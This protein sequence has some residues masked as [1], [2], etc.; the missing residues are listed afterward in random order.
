MRS[1]CLL[2]IV[3]KRVGLGT[4]RISEY[5][6]TLELAWKAAGD[7]LEGGQ[8]SGEGV[9]TSRERLMVMGAV[10]SKIY[11]HRGVCS[12]EGSNACHISEVSLCPVSVSLRTL[13]M[14]SLLAAG[15]E[16]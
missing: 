14:I 9:T 2:C 6:R 13:A 5:F 11:F 3:Q 1:A 15:R 10:A 7:P 8:M 16:C 4:C 12:C